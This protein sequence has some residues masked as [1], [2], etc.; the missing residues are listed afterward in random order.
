MIL[1][2][3]NA[4]TATEQVSDY[5]TD[6]VSLLLQAVGNSP[7]QRYRLTIQGKRWLKAQE[8]SK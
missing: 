3:I 7:T 2:T 6:Q 8:E 1:E 4:P 5:V